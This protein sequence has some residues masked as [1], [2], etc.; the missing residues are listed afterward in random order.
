MLL[1]VCIFFFIRKCYG[2]LAKNI[3]LWDKIVQH[4][5]E[6]QIISRY[7]QE[8]SYDN[9]FSVAQI[10]GINMTETFERLTIQCLRLTR[11]G[12]AY[13]YVSLFLDGNTFSQF[14]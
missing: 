2:L 14:S 12:E 9:A 4:L 10:V 7:A 5:T 6:Q 3:S 13:L 8:G 1:L 11:R